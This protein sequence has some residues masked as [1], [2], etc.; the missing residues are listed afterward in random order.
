MIGVWWR[1][2]RSEPPLTSSEN[3][4]RSILIRFWKGEG[5]LET[6]F[7]FS[8]RHRLNDRAAWPPDAAENQGLTMGTYTGTPGRIR[9]LVHEEILRFSTKGARLSGN[10]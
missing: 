9:D 7:V 8:V 4:L 5:A 2:P 6:S 10:Q 3:N 1:T